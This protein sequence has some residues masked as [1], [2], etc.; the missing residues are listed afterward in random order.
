MLIPG[1]PQVQR[2][3]V[4]AWF[5]AGSFVLAQMLAPCAALCLSHSL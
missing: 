3:R 4:L 2:A 1:L 5:G